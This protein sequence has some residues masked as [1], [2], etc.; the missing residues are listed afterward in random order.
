VSRR[1][2]RPGATAGALRAHLAIA[3][4]LFGAACA[5]QKPKGS[6]APTTAEPTGEGAGGGGGKAATPTADIDPVAAEFQ[7]ETASLD[8]KWEELQDHMK[9]F[10]RKHPE[11]APAWYD[12]GLAQQN[13]GKVEDAEESYKKALEKDSALRQAAE[14]LAALEVKKG[15]TQ[16]AERLLRSLVDRDQTAAKARSALAEALVSQGNI[17]EAATLARESLAHDPKN[18]QDYCVLARAAVQEKKHSLARLLVSQGFKVSESAGCLHF[19]LGSLLYQEKQIAQAM[20]EFE[21]AVE[22]QPDLIEARFRIAQ[23]SMGL[24]DFKKAVSSYE[25]VT[26]VDPKNAAAWVN[27]GVAFKGSAQFAEAEKAY[28]K[29]I[30]VATDQTVPEAHFDLGVLYLRNMNRPEDARTQ[31]KRYLQLGGTEGNDPAFGMLEE[32]DQLKA[33]EE[34]QKQSA[35]EEKRKEEIE[36]KAAEENAKQKAVDDA[37]KKTEEDRQKKIDEKAKKESEQKGE[38]QEPGDTPT[39]PGTKK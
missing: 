17:D 37:E 8:N 19:V 31:L 5:A 12:L 2:G 4:L 34:Q 14:N 3:L 16:G 26:K 30:E 18:M 10:T 35:E 29:A 9:S 33:M 21:K 27:M 25:A 7:S 15:D 13:L 6:E 23:I 38:P 24:K 1:T 36:K 20:E 32:I 39:I 22:Q 28:L 11:F